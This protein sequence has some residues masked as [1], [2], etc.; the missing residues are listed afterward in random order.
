MRVSVDFILTFLCG[1][2]R[3]TEGSFGVFGWVVKRFHRGF[4]NVLER[5]GQGCQRNSECLRGIREGL[6]VQRKGL[7]EDFRDIEE[8]F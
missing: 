8:G 4:Q 6:K 7:S 3:A 1:F 5:G 2:R